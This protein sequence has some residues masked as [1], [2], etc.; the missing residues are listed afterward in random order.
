VGDRSAMTDAGSTTDLR[1]LDAGARVLAL[2][3]MAT[4]PLTQRITA[5]PVRD[6]VCRR[7]GFIGHQPGNPARNAPAV[8]VVRFAEARAQERLLLKDDVARHSHD[9]DAKPRR[10]PR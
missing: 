5:C 10:N 6:Q 4:T 7:L 2:F 3:A 9:E 1:G 8:A